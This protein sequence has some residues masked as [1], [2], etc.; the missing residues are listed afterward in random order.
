MQVAKESHKYVF[1]TTGVVVVKNFLPDH[2]VQEARALISAN[3]PAGA[4][5]KFP[6]MH[7]GHIFWEMLTSTFLL[8]MCEEFCGPQFRMDHAFGLSSN[9]AIPQLHGGPQSSQYSCFYYG[10]PNGARRAIC[11][12]LN[13]GFAL[14]GQSPAT[15]GF[16]YVPGSHRQAD[17][18]VGKDILREVYS[19]H[20]DHQS[21]I[22]PTVEPGDLLMFTEGLIHGD[23]GWR[24]NGCR[25]QVYFKMTPGFMCWRDPNQNAGLAKFAQTDLE[26]KLLARPW[27]GRYEETETTMGTSNER[28]ESTRHG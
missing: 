13:F 26:R 4:P 17:P 8:D 1:D 5:W 7:L 25:M 22:V 2:M 11:G 15:G 28:K 16:V 20:F 3:W 6:V 10:T 27:T 21:L 24:A 23:T 14:Y 18:R 9:G 12:Q 19:G